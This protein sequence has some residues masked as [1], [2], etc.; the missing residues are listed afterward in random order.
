MLLR[1]GPLELDPQAERV[2]CDGG[3]VELPKLSY[4][5]LLALVTRAPHT[6]SKDELIQSVWARTAVSDETLA[7][8]A[9]LLRQALA[10]AAGDSSAHW[11]VAVRGEGYRW[12]LPVERVPRLAVTQGSDGAVEERQ[13][14][15]ARR[16]S[17]W[18]GW[19]L[20]L[21]GLVL[22]AASIGWWTAQRPMPP[23]DAGEGRELITVA[24]LPFEAEADQSHVALG[25]EDALRSRLTAVPGL[26]VRSR[27]RLSGQAEV[28]KA[29]A[30]VGGRL[31]RASDGQL[32]LALE[33]ADAGS[34]TLLW[35]D[36]FEA[37][38]SVGSL[39]DLQA[40]VAARVSSALIDEA[41]AAVQPPAR[42]GDR[43]PT[44]SIAA[45]ELYLLGRYH[46]FRQTL[47]DLRQ[48]VEHLETAVGIDPQFAQAWAALG[49]AYTF[50]G[51]SYG[52]LTPSEAYPSAREAALRAL[53]LAPNLAD[54]RSLHADILTWY[55][56]DF[57]AAEAEYQQA[58]AQDPYNTLGYALLLSVLE[59]H[60]EAIAMV[61]RRLAVSA[62]D[63]YV[64]ANAAWR[65]LN[66][67]RLPQAIS[68]ARRAESHPDAAAVLGRALLASGE[69]EQAIEVFEEDVAR[70]ARAPGQLANLAVGYYAAGNRE[71]GDAIAGELAQQAQERY[72]SSVLLARVAF[73]GGHVDEGFAY[74]EAGLEGRSRG[75]IF[76]PLLRELAGVRS[77]PRYISLLRRMG[78]RSADS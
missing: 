76:L 6:V 73:A 52:A 59:R 44:D 9:R 2:S 48:A 55:D 33:L 50:L 11:L 40:Q 38:L 72:V 34:Q 71:G 61:E 39:F 22:L 67:N 53:S 8:R 18:R 60:E 68:A 3:W 62:D 75:M 56:W 43:L 17:P 25:L 42:N 23:V 64:H 49:W 1:S 30:L 19:G 31:T 35:A 14:R 4:R 46:T 20:V 29:D 58:L 13:A 57:P 78:L 41:S 63:P 16:A 45:Y 24:V 10:P 28:P 66:A 12:Q 51:T 65:Y 7:Q 69:V 27:T 26:A 47:P 36:S 37:D 74:L 21:A 77:D 54:A 70:R 32:Q 5:L 15:A